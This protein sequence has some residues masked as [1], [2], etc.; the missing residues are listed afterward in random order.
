MIDDGIVWTAPQPPSGNVFI[1]SMIGRS[2]VG[3]DFVLYVV[4]RTVVTSPASAVKTDLFRVSAIGAFQQRVLA[5]QSCGECT[6]RT[7]TSAACLV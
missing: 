5:S 6:P 1:V 2:E 7:A 3:S 4:T